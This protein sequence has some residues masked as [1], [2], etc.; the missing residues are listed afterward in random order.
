MSWDN[1][2]PPAPIDGW[3]T[4]PAK[5]EPIL[6][7]AIPV[8][9]TAAPDAIQTDGGRRVSDSI[10]NATYSHMTPVDAFPIAQTKADERRLEE[11]REAVWT[12]NALDSAT[13][14][15]GVVNA[16]AGTKDEFNI[17]QDGEL[18]RM[19]EIVASTQPGPH[20]YYVAYHNG[21]WLHAILSGPYGSQAEVYLRAD[22]AYDMMINDAAFKLAFENKFERAGI[23][24]AQIPLSARRKGAYGVIE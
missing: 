13:T 21:R 7:W 11:L 20:G 5:R 9:R 12:A 4:P 18:T 24:C 22:K 14:K 1:V 2:K 16:L 15:A 3:G 17:D 19:R 8:P 6:D 23:Y 10:R